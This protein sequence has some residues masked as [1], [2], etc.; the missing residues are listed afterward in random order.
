QR[1]QQPPG[2]TLA[3]RVDDELQ[4]RAR[5]AHSPIS[6]TGQPGGGTPGTPGTALASLRPASTGWRTM[7]TTGPAASSWVA[8]SSWPPAAS[9]ARQAPRAYDA[10]A[11][12]RSPSQVRSTTTAWRTGD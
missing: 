12:V 6:T 11:S 9:T 5:L 1:C 2:H 3:V 10:A 4:R 7:P 8:T